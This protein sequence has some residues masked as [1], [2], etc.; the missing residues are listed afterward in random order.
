MTTSNSNSPKTN[1][2][3]AVRPLNH[4]EVQLRPAPLW[5]K[6]LAWTI[7]STASLGFIFAVFAK[8]DE[9]VLAPGE[10]QPLGA[11]RPVKAP[12]AG[13][14]KDIVAKEG[15]KVNAGDT[16]LRFDADV[17][18]KRKETLETQI[19]L[20]RKRFEE[21]SRA[22]EARKRGVVERLNGI[23]R[24]L[25]TESSIYTNIIPLAEIGAMQ[26]TELLRQ[27]NKVEQLE[28]E[29]QV[30]KADLEEVEAQLNKLKQ[31][32]LREISELERQMVEVQ[33]TITKEKLSAPIAGIVYGMI[34]SSAGYAASAGETLVKVVPG[35]E[36]EAKIYIT[37]Q[38]VGFMKS[39]M[40]AQIRVDA[41]PYTQFGSITGSLKSV[42]TLPLEPD[43]QNPMPRFPAYVKIDKDY[44][45]KDGEKYEISAGQSVQVNL[46]LRDKRVI[47]LLTDAVQ[48]ALD[49]LTRIKSSK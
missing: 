9:V 21:E 42:G 45:E 40:K 25:N 28:S 13:V 30:V 43:Q 23:N 35:G 44:L 4:Q 22:V 41:F 26:L 33:D 3:L 49:S 37:N 14:I 20:E 17:S 5:S 32:S 12:F 6:A 15:Q 8:I 27:R 36:I 19:K 24:S 31:E 16:L 7:I 10:L 29:A 11:E 47:S 2:S 34:P 48:K 18:R 39:G 46:I 1:S 38:D